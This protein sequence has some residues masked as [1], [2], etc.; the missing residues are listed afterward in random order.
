MSRD[1]N[2]DESVFGF[3]ST[4]LDEDA[5]DFDFKYLDI[6]DCAVPETDYMQ[7]GKQMGRLSER[8][9]STR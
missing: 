2:F 9:N 3:L 8:K 7:T 1:V 4:S 5:D 6:D